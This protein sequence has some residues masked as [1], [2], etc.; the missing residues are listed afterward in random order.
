MA[1]HGRTHEAPREGSRTPPPGETLAMGTVPAEHGVPGIH[2][3]DFVLRRLRFPAGTSTGWHYHP[4]CLYV[5]VEHG[6]LLHCEPDGTTRCYRAGD[7]FVEP[8]GPDYVHCG[9]AVGPETVHLAA[10]YLNP[11]G[12]EL[13]VPAPPPPAWASDRD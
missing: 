11:R 9:T 1:D 12:G 8:E 13:V 4:G 6:E 2:G 10:L 3:R 5:I 7:A